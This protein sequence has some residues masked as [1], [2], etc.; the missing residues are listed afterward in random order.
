MK[1]TKSK[2]CI[3]VIAIAILVA[4]LVVALLDA[5]I[6]LNFWTHTALNFFFCAFLGF[7]VLSLTFGIKKK[8]SWFVF[9]GAIL[10]GLAIFYA[11]FQYLVWWL[12]LIAVIVLWGILVTI[13]YV[14][15]GNKIEDVDNNKPEY[16]NYE[17][18]RAEKLEA[19]NNAEKE[20]LPEIKSFK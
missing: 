6:P 3:G 8:A 10:L 7:G 13:G 12:A 19:E 14:V 9:F 1:N 15:L 17:Q 2:M 16:K 4:S 20:D 18:R 11:L 5:I